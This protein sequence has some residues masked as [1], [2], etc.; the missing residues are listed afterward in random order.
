MNT[1][2]IDK[3]LRR[4]ALTRGTYVGCF[5]A[6]QIPTTQYNNNSKKYPH[7]MVVNLDASNCYGS[8]WVAIYVCSPTSVEYYDSLG[9]WPPPS[10]HICRH[11]QRFAHCKYNRRQW[12]S[13]RSSACGKHA[14]YFL[15]RRCAGR[16]FQEIMQ[17][18]ARCKQ[19]ADRIVSAFVRTRIFN[20]GNGVA[21]ESEISCA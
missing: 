1:L 11:L 3:V 17:H 4:S 7:H 6:D 18:F 21:D 13:E 15:Q 19:N 10:A 2:Q 16:S 5:A 12:Q 20:S 14:I 9:D 8:H